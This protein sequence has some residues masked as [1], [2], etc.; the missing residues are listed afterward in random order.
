M[1]LKWQ[2]RGIR[3]RLPFFH[4][5]LTILEEIWFLVTHS[6]P[7]PV[8]EIREHV[9]CAVPGIGIYAILCDTCEVDRVAKDEEE[10][11]GVRKTETRLLWAYSKFPT[12][13][14]IS[15]KHNNSVTHEIPIWIYPASEFRPRGS[16]TPII[17]AR[18]RPKKTI[19]SLGFAWVYYYY[20]A[21]AGRHTKQNERRILQFTI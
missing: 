2:T 5:L 3:S 21:T 19:W 18:A 10:M 16:T 9:C 13:D 11:H 4:V 15:C 17:T 14:N 1:I 20:C 7:V 6:S 8:R 12:Q